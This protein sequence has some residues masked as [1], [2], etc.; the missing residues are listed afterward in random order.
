MLSSYVKHRIVALRDKGHKAPTIALEPREEGSHVSRVGV[1]KF[2]RVYN[3][4]HTVQH[5]SSSGRLARS[6][7]K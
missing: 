3:T 4:T 2:L 1:H 7:Q 5:R 6:H